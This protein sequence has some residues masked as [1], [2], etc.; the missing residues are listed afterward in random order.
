MEGWEGPQQVSIGDLVSVGAG[1]SLTAKNQHLAFR[2]DSD[3]IR[4]GGDVRLE[5]SLFLGWV[6]G[7][8]RPSPD[9]RRDAP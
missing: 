9:P 4:S 7:N 6:M 3:P 1:R 2:T 5:N 8:P